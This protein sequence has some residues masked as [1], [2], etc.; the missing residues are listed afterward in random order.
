MEK[1]I[2]SLYTE[3]LEKV[4]HS[5]KSINK[6]H[7]TKLLTKVEYI[8]LLIKAEKQQGE[9]GYQQ[10]IYYYEELKKQTPLVST[11]EEGARYESSKSWWEN[12]GSACTL[13]N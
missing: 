11:V 10:R 3:V 12:S 1:S 9:D 8:E 6:L 4:R 2:K 7:G 13:S 5:K